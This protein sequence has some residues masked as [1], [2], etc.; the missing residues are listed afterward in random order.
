MKADLDGIFSKEDLAPETAIEVAKQATNPEEMSKIVYGLAYYFSKAILK[1]KADDKTKIEALL[2]LGEFAD[3]FYM[4]VKAFPFLVTTFIYNRTEE[5]LLNSI[6]EH[7]VDFAYIYAN[8]KNGKPLEDVTHQ[9][10]L[11]SLSPRMLL[12]DAFNHA[13]EIIAYLR[14]ELNGVTAKA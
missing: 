10:F 8:L 5:D 11:E 14:E 1:A 9:L 7:F 12:S 2:H 13:N 6:K 3:A 4:T